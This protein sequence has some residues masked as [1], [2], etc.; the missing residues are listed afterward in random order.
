MKQMCLWL[1]LSCKRYLKRPS[2]VLI[3]LLFPVS[4]WLFGL[5][6]QDGDQK[7]AVAVCA[8]GDQTGELGERLLDALEA[9]GSLEDGMFRFYPVQDDLAVQ[10]EV[11]SRRA[12]CGY[13]IGEN[14]EEKLSQKQYRRTITVYSAPSTVTATLS[15]EVVFSVLME[16]YDR[17]LLQDYVRSDELFDSLGEPDGEARSE[18]S[19]QAG[20]LYDKWLTNDSTFRFE[21]ESVARSAG[22][23]NTGGETSST[24]FPVRGILAIYVF[25]TGLFAAVTVLWD[26][27][28]GLFLPLSYASRTPCR[29]ACLAAPVLLAA[30][31]GLAAVGAA[32]IGTGWGRESFILLVFASAVVLFSWILAKLCPNPNVLCCLI[33]F[34]LVSCLVFCPVFLDVGRYV[35]GISW[36]GKCLLPY[37]YMIAF[38]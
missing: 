31:S 30:L 5:M 20:S 2:F 22:E 11:A 13:V 18:L 23:G 16:L 26:E 25:M 7:I 34:F 38:R 6:E 19:A 15:T 12:E 3:L 32:G 27:K 8:E 9:K 37:Y 14:F 4:A 28:K 36:V 33:P 24:R 35:K 1:L 10:E 29:L 21:Y 17:T